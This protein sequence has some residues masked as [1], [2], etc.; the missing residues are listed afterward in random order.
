V[1]P[2]QFGT[3]CVPNREALKKRPHVTQVA[4]IE[5]LAELLRQHLPQ[6][7]QKPLAV[8][9]TGLAALLELD[10]MPTDLPTGLH[11]HLVHMAQHLLAGLGDQAAQGIQQTMG[12]LI[13]WCCGGFKGHGATSTAAG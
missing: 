9:R 11:L 6:L 4:L 1:G 7:R 2:A 5:T 8:A 13:V 10:D 3:H 12:G